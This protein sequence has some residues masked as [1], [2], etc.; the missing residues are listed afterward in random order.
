[1]VAIKK[2]YFRI[3]L[4]TFYFRTVCLA[5]KFG[6]NQN[7]KIFSHVTSKLINGFKTKWIKSCSF[8]S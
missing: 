4:W 6:P 5:F 8:L 1:M 2:L 7:G 3:M